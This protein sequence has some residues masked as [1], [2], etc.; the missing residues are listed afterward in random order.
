MRTAFV[1]VVLVAAFAG[2]TGASS[3]AADA[4]DD[5]ASVGA[6]DATS[7]LDGA[8]EGGDV[9]EG[10]DAIY[11]LGDACDPVCTSCGGPDG[12]G[13]IC[14]TGACEAG[15]QSCEAGSCVCPV[16]GRA[17][18]RTDHTEL[19]M[20]GGSVTST[21]CD[22]GCVTR[23]AGDLCVYFSTA[24][25][26]C[27]TSNLGGRQI[28]VCSTADGFIHKCDGTKAIEVRCPKRCSPA[29]L[30]DAVCP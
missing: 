8:G 20:P 2:C 27:A 22:D 23:A 3:S 30:T 15:I 25:W 21:A 14:G 1:A 17:V 28:W 24:A 11:T 4:G 26:N 29:F 9:G 13:G 19:C 18:C 16:T 7:M 10:L 5:A 6:T 12:C